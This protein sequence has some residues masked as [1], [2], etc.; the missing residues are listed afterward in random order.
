MGAMFCVKRL[1]TARSKADAEAERQRGRTKLGFGGVAAREDS[2]ARVLIR[3]ARALV[4]KAAVAAQTHT[5]T[6][7]APDHKSA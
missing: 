1:V 6:A 4:D 3:S 7:N 2:E 5:K